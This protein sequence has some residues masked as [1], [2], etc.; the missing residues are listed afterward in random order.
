MKLKYLKEA[1]FNIY[2][3]VRRS[4]YIFLGILETLIS[5][6]EQ[7]VYVLSYHSVCEDK[8]RFSIDAKEIKKQINYLA[9]RFTII[10]LETLE[11][12]ITKKKK[13]LT[14]SIV[15]TFD[16]G[17]KDIMKLRKFFKSKNIKPAIFLL[18]D[19]THANWNELGS[20]RQFLNKSEIHSLYR[21]GYEIGSHSKT[22]ANLSTLYGKKLESEV[23]GSRKSLEKSFGIPIR[24]FAYPRG[25][26]TD[27]VLKY[28]KKAG[29]KLALTMDDG[30]ISANTHP[31]LVPRIGV[32]RTHTFLEFKYLFSK[33][34]I[35]M[36]MLIKRSYV[37]R[38]I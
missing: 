14:P 12:I 1:L 17:Y 21:D 8:W 7:N 31:L 30:F 19:T 37:G 2:I 36:R 27:E 13:V 10:D 20:K 9:E 18:A 32:D 15:I 28:V 26:Y 23:I 34:N 24:Y 38:Y 4:I 16:D 3:S 29:Y 6:E 35:N 25:K 33:S 22:H 5:K 11:K